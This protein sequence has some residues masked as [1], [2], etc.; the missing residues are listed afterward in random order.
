MLQLLS[1][2]P[3]PGT[4]KPQ[5]RYQSAHMDVQRNAVRWILVTDIVGSYTYKPPKPSDP[6]HHH[7][8]TTVSP[9]TEAL[10]PL[11][12][13]PHMSRNK[14]DQIRITSLQATFQVPLGTVSDYETEPARE[15]TL[16]YTACA[17]PLRNRKPSIRKDD[18][19]DV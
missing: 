14:P 13:P 17:G 6:E 9:D 18:P 5:S 3:Y 12:K 7:T 2:N 10:E 16:T 1:E 11:L 4:L 8:L 15:G 19:M